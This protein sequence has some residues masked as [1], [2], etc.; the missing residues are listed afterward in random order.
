MVQGILSSSPHSIAFFNNV[1]NTVS[2]LLTVFGARSAIASF[3]F[4][5]CSFVIHRGVSYRASAADAV[6]QWI[7]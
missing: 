2:T 3:S 5:T 6:S 1:L 4:C 7:L